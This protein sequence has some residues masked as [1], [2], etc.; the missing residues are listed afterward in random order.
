MRQNIQTKGRLYYKNRRQAHNQVTKKPMDNGAKGQHAY[1][2]G[3]GDLFGNLFIT[4]IE[5]NSYDPISYTLIVPQIESARILEA[6][7]LV[8]DVCSMWKWTFCETA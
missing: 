7:N 1:A 3:T 2:F 6:S 5:C 8:N 4:W